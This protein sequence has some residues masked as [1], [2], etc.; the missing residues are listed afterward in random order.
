MKINDYVGIIML[1]IGIIIYFYF[2]AINSHD[3]KLI[4]VVVAFA[5]I[6]FIVGQFSDDKLIEELD[7]FLIF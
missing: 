7:D 6:L 1:I 5:S 2:N 4:G 3:Y